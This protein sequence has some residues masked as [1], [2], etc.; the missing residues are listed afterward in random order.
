MNI[1]HINLYINHISFY[2]HKNIN[3]CKVCLSAK[4]MLHR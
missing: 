4:V 1:L 3:K 2:E